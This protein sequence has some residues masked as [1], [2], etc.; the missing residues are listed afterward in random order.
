MSLY[1]S[2]LNYKN[3]I[4]MSTY[5]VYLHQCPDRT[6]YVGVTTLEPELRW[7]N[8]IGY[9]N[10]SSFY[11]QI[12]FFGWNN[13]EHIILGQTTDKDEALMLED[14]VITMLQAEGRCLNTN[15]SGGKAC[16]KERKREYNKQYNEA[17]AEHL[18][19][20]HKRYYEVHKENISERNKHYREANAEHIR[21]QKKQ[22]R[23]AHKEQ[24]KQYNTKRNSTPERKIYIRVRDF[25]RYHPDRAIETP[26]EAKQKYLEYG[27][28]P[29]YIK[30]DD[31]Q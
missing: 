31:L 27:Y 23:E 3:V 14:M 13:I 19:E 12:L 2:M 18:K 1:V 26:M 21:E 22:Y 24:V 28:I 15:K 9:K 6:A 5:T 20:L 10:H 8:G 4:Y 17:N 30:N 16:S 7:K 29:D 11:D 25:N